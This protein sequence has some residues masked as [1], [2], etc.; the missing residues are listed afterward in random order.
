M[1][2]NYL[3]IT[4]DD[5]L[6]M[7]DAGT[8]PIRRNPDSGNYIKDGST[9][10]HDWIGIVAPED[11]INILNPKRGYIVNANNKIAPDDYYHGQFRY[12]QFTAR[13]DRIVKLIK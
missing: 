13:M 4:K 9:S 12:G 5:N 11:R 10:Q 1:N 6:M 3:F 7:Q 2:I 8:H